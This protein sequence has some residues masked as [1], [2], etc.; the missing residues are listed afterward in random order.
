MSLASLVE[1][2]LILNDAHQFDIKDS[3]QRNQLRAVCDG[4][5][6]FRQITLG[7]RLLRRPFYP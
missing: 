5:R 1:R 4:D 7:W 3:T 6:P 2:T